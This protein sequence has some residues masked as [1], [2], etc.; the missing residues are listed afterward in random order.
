[1]EE[2]KKLKSF[3][4]ANYIDYKDDIITGKN[5]GKNIDLNEDNTIK[6]GVTEDLQFGTVFSFDSLGR[7]IR[8]TKN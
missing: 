2:I 5:E 7:E 6:S 1:M 3:L 8:I 4:Q